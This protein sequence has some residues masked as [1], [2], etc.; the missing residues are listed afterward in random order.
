MRMFNSPC[1]NDRMKFIDGFFEKNIESNETVEVNAGG[2]CNDQIIVSY[3]C[4][5]NHK[6]N[7]ETLQPYLQEVRP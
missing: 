4:I 2:R 7:S 6:Y 1:Y 5:N 3:S